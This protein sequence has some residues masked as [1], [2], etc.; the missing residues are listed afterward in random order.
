M[1]M[2]TE[3]QRA[4]LGLYW[5]ERPETLESATELCV[6]AFD[7]LADAG[8]TRFYEKGKSRK[9][10][11][12]RPFVP[13]RETL[14]ALLA[15]GRNRRDTDHAVIEDLGFRLALWSGDAE[16]EAYQVSVHVGVSCP[17]VSNSFVLNLPRTGPLALAVHEKE[18]RALLS[19]LET[20]FRPE[21]SVLESRS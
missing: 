6:S 16:G 21:K 14:A 15:R 3:N 12:R 7:A 18:L 8:F 10:A 20:I 2:D 5:S 4:I 1:A 11:L 19:Q 17:F 13:T 9:D